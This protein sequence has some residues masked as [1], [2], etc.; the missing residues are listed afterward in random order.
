MLKGLSCHLLVHPPSYPLLLITSFRCPLT[1]ALLCSLGKVPVILPS[2]S[3]LLLHYLPQ[4]ST[5]C[6]GFT[7]YFYTNG[8]SPDL[9]LDSTLGSPRHFHIRDLQDP[10][11]PTGTESVT[12]VTILSSK[13]CPTTC[14]SRLPCLPQRLLQPF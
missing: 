4:P 3:C 14:P 2:S 9:S 7:R 13:S 11:T 5:L 1:R 12:G 8:S 10:H 6:G